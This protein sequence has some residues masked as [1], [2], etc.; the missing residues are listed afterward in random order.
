MII[1]LVHYFLDPKGKGYEVLKS[2]QIHDLFLKDSLYIDH[3]ISILLVVMVF[4][5][6]EAA[7]YLE[8]WLIDCL[9]KKR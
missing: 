3:V 9:H 1:G 5:L 4:A 6:V 8:P 7:I 2:E